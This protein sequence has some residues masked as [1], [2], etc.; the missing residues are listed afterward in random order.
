MNLKPKIP[1]ILVVDDDITTNTILQKIMAR[2]GFAATAAY[3]AAEAH[4]RVRDQVPDLVLLDINLPDAD[5]LDVCHQLRGSARTSRTPVLFISANHDLATK[6]RGFE[7]GAVDYI[8]K[9]F[10]FEEVVARVST[11][12]RLKQAY[13]SLADLQ[14]ERVQRLTR[15]QEILMPRPA[16]LPAAQFAV[17][18]QQVLQAGGDFYDVIPVGGNVFDYIVAD[19]SGHDL[20]AAL[21]T[22]ALKALLGEYASPINSPRDVLQSINSALGRIL[23]PGVFFTLIYARLNRQTGRLSL[24]NAGHPPA[25]VMHRQ[26]DQ[27]TIVHQEGDVLGAF[28]D[29]SFGAMDLQL[30]PG[31]RFFLYSDGLIEWSG[32]RET[33]LHRLLS[34]CDG[35]RTGTLQENVSAVFAAVAAEAAAKDDVLFM[36]VEV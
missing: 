30:R 4:N 36:G 18:M 15:A 9:P 27:S 12:L 13:E 5:G 25:I 33:G 34:A 32:Q 7:A 11:H 22:A 10:A 17:S 6:V 24:A 14:A 21:W 28:A 23:P 35:S 26:A 3:T 16:D 1:Q 29:G 20:A 8:P 19:A 31:D 2:A